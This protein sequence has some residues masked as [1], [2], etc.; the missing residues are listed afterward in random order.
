LPS[1]DPASSSPGPLARQ[2]TRSLAQA[3]AGTTQGGAGSQSTASKITLAAQVPSKCE[4]AP[5]QTIAKRTFHQPAAAAVRPI[6]PPPVLVTTSPRQPEWPVAAGKPP[7]ASGSSN[8]PSSAST[9][10][11]PASGAACHP[12]EKRSTELAE[13]RLV[14]SAGA[15]PKTTV[16]VTTNRRRQA[17]SVGRGDNEVAARQRHALGTKPASGTKLL[18]PMHPDATVGRAR[19]TPAVTARSILIP[20]GKRT[21]CEPQVHAGGVHNQLQGPMLRRGSAAS[22]GPGHRPSETQ[23][24]VARP[25]IQRAAV[26]SEISEVQPDDVHERVPSPRGPL[27]LTPTI[28]SSRPAAWHW[29]HCLEP[30][31]PSTAASV[32]PS[33]KR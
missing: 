17:T 23:R 8:I 12:T 14:P 13:A 10:P 30:C 32:S 15:P 22:A 9:P 1:A 29:G 27:A 25:F 21:R 3:A 19:S 18:A 4:Y 2:S 31:P 33:P 28:P 6:L 16:S 26:G 5:S 20:R 24:A 7:A 11:P